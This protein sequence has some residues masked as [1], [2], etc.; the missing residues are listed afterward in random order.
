MDA[1][2]SPPLNAT[3]PQLLLNASAITATLAVAPGAH[4]AVRRPGGK[5]AT[6]ETIHRLELLGTRR[7]THTGYDLGGN[8]TQVVELL[9]GPQEERQEMVG[10]FLFEK[11]DLT[12]CACGEAHGS[13]MF[14]AGHGHMIKQSAN[15]QTHIKLASLATKKN[16]HFNK[17]SFK[18]KARTH[19]QKNKHGSLSYLTHFGVVRNFSNCTCLLAAICAHVAGFHLWPKKTSVFSILK[20]THFIKTNKNVLRTPVSALGIVIQLLLK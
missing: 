3:P 11:I 4:R 12:G 5:G 10:V 13:S 20:Y 7:A 15:K 6:V 14:G 9:I 16:T 8:A 18:Q 2:P 1:S 19:T 17:C